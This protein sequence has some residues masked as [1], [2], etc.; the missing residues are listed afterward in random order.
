MIEDKKYYRNL[1]ITVVSLFVIFMIIAGIFDL[2]ISKAVHTPNS[3][4]G[5]FFAEIGEFPLN[6]APLVSFT[7]IYQYIPW[8]NKQYKPIKALSVVGVIAGG[9]IFWRYL[10]NHLFDSELL[11][12]NVYVIVFGLV[13]AFIAIVL[14]NS[15]D[16]ELIKKLIIFALFYLAVAYALR[17]FVAITKETW[18]RLRFNY[19]NP[20][21]YE[22]FTPWWKINF[23]VRGREHLAYEEFR[24]TA[25][26]SFMS[27]HTTGAGACF[28]IIILPDLFDTLKKYRKFFYIAPL[29]Y[30]FAVA[31]SRVVIGAHFLSDVIAATM[32]SYVIAILLRNLFLSK[33]VKSLLPKYNPR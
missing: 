23:T 1:N 11:F 28:A 6:I 4:F 18:L 15:L 24:T 17:L 3:F 31:L 25:F 19:M 33:K 21:T 7:I 12:L 20:E 22:G 8:E 29:M 16:K 14:T 9:L 26:R 30:T 27:G 13:T 5:N 2:Q 32:S 10:A